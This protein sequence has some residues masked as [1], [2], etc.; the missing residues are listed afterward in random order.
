MKV[1][2]IEQHEQVEVEMDGASRTKMRMLIGPEDGAC[3]FHMRHFEVE[4]GGHTPHHQH[5]HEHEI[6]VLSGVGT[7]ASETGERPFKAGDVIF[8]PAGEAHQFVNSGEAPCTFICLIPAL[9]DCCR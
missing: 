4:P 8:V 2:P 3:C 1:Q 5:D 6:L 7:A 9:R